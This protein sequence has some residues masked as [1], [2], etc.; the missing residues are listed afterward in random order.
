[1]PTAR[2]IRWSAFLALL[3]ALACAF[4]D[5]TP[6]SPAPVPA[7]SAVAEA[8][9]IAPLAS[10]SLL[11]DIAAAGSRIVVV[12]ERGQ[13]LLS[14]DQGASWRQPETPTRS[15][16]TAVHFA[17]ASHGWAVGHDEVILR[18]EDGGEHWAR[19]HF[20]PKASQPLLDVWF[21]DADRGIAV[22]AYS[23]LF[24]SADGGRSWQSQAFSPV[25]KPPPRHPQATRP[26]PAADVDDAGTQ[27]HLNAIG[28][29]A[30]GKLYIAAESGHLYR[31]DDGGATWLTLSSP[32]EGS[33]F[34]VLPLDGDSV[35]AFGMRGHLFRSDNAGD[36]WTQI[37]T[38]AT[39]MLTSG[40]RLPNDVVA[41]TGLAGVLLVS[42][43]GGHT[44]SVQQQAD[45]L[46]MSSALLVDGRFIT[47]GEGGV[48]LRPLK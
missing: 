4:A 39:A 22:G 24:T 30:S 13:V 5:Q 21:R 17:D 44:F 14:D 8:A 46:G 47:V 27:F 41:I 16:L 29:A 3:V 23:A 15:S 6:Q 40:V 28:A 37:K 25:L 38:D 18:T 1:V 26:L 48:L 2:G 42:K 20:E 33:F 43:D 10:R 7:S 36:S 12:G 45:R 34:G 9:E 31:S 11:L 32:Y 19:V 35:L